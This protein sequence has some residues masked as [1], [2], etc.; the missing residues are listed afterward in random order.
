KRARREMAVEA[1][2][3]RGH[4]SRFDLSYDPGVTTDLALALLDVLENA[5]NQV[6]AGLGH[7]PE[8]RVPVVIYQRDGFKTVTDS[9]DWSGGI[10]DGTIR[11]PYGGLKEITP[12]MRGV[13][14][15]EYAHVVVFDLT[16]GNC[17]LWLNEGIAEWFGRTQYNRPMADLSRAARQGTFADFR[18]LEGS[19]SGFSRQ[20]AA[21][22]YQQS[23]AMVD[24]L[25]ATYGWHRVKELLVALGNGMN[26][27]AAI[28]AAWKEYGL[29]YAGLVRE[30]QGYMERNAMPR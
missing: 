30:W 14:F 11:L 17:P 24:Y 10:Y 7:F 19:F 21:L 9:P 28:A 8:A 3:D 29:S 12:P 23:Y 15:H 5:A 20:D 18:R 1:G 22:A 2:M 26:V 25:V 27:E 16:R 4:S 13:L 6:G